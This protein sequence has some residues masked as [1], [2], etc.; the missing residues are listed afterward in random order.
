[1]LDLPYPVQQPVGYSADVS[2]AGRGA[3]IAE[4]LA[5]KSTVMPSVDYGKA[6][7]TVGTAVGLLVGDPVGTAA[8]LISAG[9]LTF[10]LSLVTVGQFYKCCALIHVHLLLNY[11]CC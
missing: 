5:T 7:L 10:L 8:L 3:L 9:H 1:M 6:G 2:D 11:A 4:Y